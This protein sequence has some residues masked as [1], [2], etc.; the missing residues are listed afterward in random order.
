LS[1]EN[2]LRVL[3]A[4]AAGPLSHAEL[5]KAAALS[6]TAAANYIVTLRLLKRIEFAEFAP[7]KAGGG[8]QAAR[9]R[10]TRKA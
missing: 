3:D 2:T 10:L 1:I 9:Y 4:F 5:M 6:H 7:M 8:A